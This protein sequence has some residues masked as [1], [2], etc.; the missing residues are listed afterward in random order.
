MQQIVREHPNRGVV[1]HHNTAVP[2]VIRKNINEVGW[3]V[4]THRTYSSVLAQDGMFQHIQLFT[5]PCTDWNVLTHPN[6][7]QSLHYLTFI[8]FTQGLIQAWADWA[9]ALGSLVLGNLQIWFEIFLKLIFS[10]FY[11][12]IP[13][14]INILFPSGRFR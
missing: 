8:G 14:I 12:L 10:I 13:S 5:S 7:H 6:T 2:L 9:M 3:N 4:L 11:D 1:F